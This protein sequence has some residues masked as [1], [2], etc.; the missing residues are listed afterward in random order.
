MND[1]QI[2]EKFKGMNE[3]IP[4]ELKNA[5]VL[6]NIK[7]TIVNLIKMCDDLLKILSHIPESSQ[8]GTILKKYSDSVNKMKLLFK[9]EF[10]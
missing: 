6:N 2:F 5:A 1:K 7:V 4:I 3:D 8:Y 10:K 9:E